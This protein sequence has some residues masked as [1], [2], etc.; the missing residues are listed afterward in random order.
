MAS[1]KNGILYTGVTSKKIALIE[2][3][4]LEW[5][6]LYPGIIWIFYNK[7]IIDDL[8]IELSLMH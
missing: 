3:M 5:K 4:N 6:D 1:K 7:K 2:A 8:N